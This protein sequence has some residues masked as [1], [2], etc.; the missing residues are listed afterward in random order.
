MLLTSARPPR[1]TKTGSNHRMRRKSTGKRSRSRA[2]RTVGLNGSEAG[3]ADAADSLP[4]GG[5]RGRIARDVDD[6]TRR[7]AGNR[8]HDA[9]ARAGPR[10]VEYEQVGIF[11]PRDLL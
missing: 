4:G 1:R 7:H 3:G 2:A 8:T 5:E 11:H 10:R 6:A 9:G